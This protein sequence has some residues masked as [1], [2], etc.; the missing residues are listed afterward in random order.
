M[1]ITINAPNGAAIFE[2]DRLLD[3]VS[4]Y[5]EVTSTDWYSDGAEVEI[6]ALPLPPECKRAIPCPGE[7][8][9]WVSPRPGCAATATMAK[10]LTR[11]DFDR[12]EKKVDALT[13]RFEKLVRD[14][15]NRLATGDERGERVYMVRVSAE[16][17]GA[18]A[19]LE[20]FAQAT[21]G[22]GAAS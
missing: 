2:G 13:K 7:R 16:C 4:H 8:L 11:A 14:N 21:K 20:Q 12:L 6:R 3:S 19:T 15:A 22:D 17:N 10:P 5:Y 9:T 18:L 1:K